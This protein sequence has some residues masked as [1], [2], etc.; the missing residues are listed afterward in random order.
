MYY[1]RAVLSDFL[2][3]NFST[4]FPKKL[5][6]SDLTEIFPVRAA[7][8]RADRRTGMRQA[9][10]LLSTMRARLKIKYFVFISR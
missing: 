7:L 8:I 2:T 4:D 3:W 5:S 6:I 9:M 1:A 10:S